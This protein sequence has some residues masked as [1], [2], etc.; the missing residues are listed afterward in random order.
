M[1]RKDVIEGITKLGYEQNRIVGNVNHFFTKGNMRLAYFKPIVTE[2]DHVIALETRKE[3]TKWSEASFLTS[4]TDLNQMREIV[5]S[6]E[7]EF[8]G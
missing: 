6:A 7:Q 1:K 2:Y 4:F 3:F 5:A 8:A